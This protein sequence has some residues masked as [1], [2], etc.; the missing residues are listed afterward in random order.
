MRFLR[1][2]SQYSLG[3]VSIVLTVLSVSTVVSIR[4]H[5]FQLHVVLRS[6]RQDDYGCF[7]S[8][9]ESVCHKNT[10]WSRSALVRKQR[11]I[12]EAEVFCIVPCW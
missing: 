4:F 10:S 9:I 7:G 2:F 8:R 5:I 3:T 11:L 12:V 1:C 6:D